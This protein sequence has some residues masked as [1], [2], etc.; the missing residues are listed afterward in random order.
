MRSTKNRPAIDALDMPRLEL[1]DTHKS[2]LQ[3]IITL[4]ITVNYNTQ[5]KTCNVRLLVVA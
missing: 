5:N 2:Q 1:L 4:K 3:I